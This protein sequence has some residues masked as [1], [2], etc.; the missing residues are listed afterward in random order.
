M[1]TLAAQ[2]GTS[3][4]DRQGTRDVADTVARTVVIALFTVMAVRLGLDFMDTGRLTGLLLLASEA[5]V[6][7]FIVLRRRARVVDRTLAARVITGMSML[8]PPLLRAGTEAPLLPDAVT[9]AV[10]VAGVLLVIAAKLTLGR[11]FGLVPAN[12]GVVDSGPYNL[13]RHP[14]YTGYVISHIGFL[15]AH[16]TV[17]NI[18]LVVAGDA[19]L[20]LRALYEERTLVEDDRYRAYCGRVGWHFVPG[21]F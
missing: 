15:A 21:V 1:D 20:V 2:A 16:P 3:E 19:A 14:I 4:E 7:V 10:S 9:A 12:R 5:L 8:G 17:M 11:S 13:M 6:V 18:G